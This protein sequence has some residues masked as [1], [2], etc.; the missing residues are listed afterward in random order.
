MQHE[1]LHSSIQLFRFQWKVLEWQKYLL[2][3]IA[4][5]IDSIIFRLHTVKDYQPTGI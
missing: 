3:L 1:A 2:W 5:E 4:Q